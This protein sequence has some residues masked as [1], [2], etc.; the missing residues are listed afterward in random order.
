VD[1]RDH[2]GARDGWGIVANASW[3]FGES[4]WLPFLRAG[5]ADGDATLLDA[6]LSAGVA[7]GF[8]ERDLL[9]VGISWGS[10]SLGGRDQWTGEIFYRSQIRNLAITPSLQLIADPSRHPDDDLLVVGGL[11]VRLVF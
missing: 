11:R 5:W 8:R 6:Q 4:R 7:R 2:A 1:E 10:P 3:H 9:G